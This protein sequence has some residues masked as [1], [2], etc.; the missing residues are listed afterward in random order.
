MEL[1]SE[2]DA[3]PTIPPDVT[4]WLPNPPDELPNGFETLPNGLDEV[5]LLAKPGCVCC[6]CWTCALCSPAGWAPKPPGELIPPP[7]PKPPGCCG[8]WGCEFCSPAGWAPKPPG[9]LIPPPAPKPPGCCGFCV[10]VDGGVWVGDVD[11]NGCCP[12][13]E[14]PNRAMFPNIDCVF[15]WKTFEP[16]KLPS[17]LMVRKRKSLPVIGSL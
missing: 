2:S 4:P 17:G 14:F 10:C 3:T 16:F 9:E 13:V 7:V 5:P 6:G 1:L 8:C 12:E 11:P 15:C